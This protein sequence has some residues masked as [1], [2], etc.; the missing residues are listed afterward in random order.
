MHNDNDH[1][2][3]WQIAKFAGYD[4]ASSG[5]TKEIMVIGG[6]FGG[7]SAVENLRKTGAQIWLVDRR[8]HHVF[9]PLLYQVATAALSPAEIGYPIRRIFRKRKDVHVV[10]DELIALDLHRNVAI[11]PQGEANYDYLILAC[12][13]THS[14]FGRDDWAKF[15]PGLKSI[16]DALEIRSRVLMAFEEA[17]M[18]ADEQLRKAN[19]TFVIVG[20]GPTGV[21]MAGALRQIATQSLPNDFRNIDTKSTRVILIQS[22]PRLLPG[23]PET[24]SQHA[25]NDLQEMGVEV[26]LGARVTDIGDGWVMIGTEKVI[27]RCIFWA[28]GVKANPVTATAGV[29]LDNNGR[30]LTNPDLSLPGFPNV[31]AIGDIA[32]VK[33][34]KSGQLVPG[35]A[36]GAIQMGQFV[37]KLISNEINKK[38]TPTNRPTFHYHDKGQMATIGRCR[39]VAEIGGYHFRGVLAWL[40]WGLVHVL[41]LVGFRN[42]FAVLAQWLWDYVTF[43]KGAR[44]ITG[45]LVPR[46]RTYHREF[47]IPEKNPDQTGQGSK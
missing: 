16:E 35:V 3:G 33:D 2:I 27:A 34:P 38:S 17:E 29:P 19:L 1:C 9:Q 26:R 11:F 12:G 46:V 43:S 36:Q 32:A 45:N 47:L 31:F 14:Y 20:G 4:S 28:A 44:L 8:N 37:G 39:A 40:L 25:L 22:A 21:E 13:A 18:E 5:P 15:A 42:R 30:I 24:L 41:F 23:M 6:G 10:M 7:L